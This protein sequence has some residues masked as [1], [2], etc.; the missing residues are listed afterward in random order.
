MGYEEKIP[1]YKTP[2]KN[3]YLCNFSQLYPMDR[4]I[5]YSI[6]DG[7]KMA[8]LISSDLNLDISK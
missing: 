5:N 7:Y 2:L 8:K 6:R 1:S 3:V 4:G